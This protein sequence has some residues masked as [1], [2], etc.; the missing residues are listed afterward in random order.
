MLLFNNQA[1]TRI[2]LGK[3]QET[4]A[5]TTTPDRETMVNTLP[6]ILEDADNYISFE[7]LYRD[8]KKLFK[9]GMPHLSKKKQIEMKAKYPKTKECFK[10][11][12][13]AKQYIPRKIKK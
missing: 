8:F 7:E 9:A 5:N 3:M 10:N 2:N 4:L 11:L 12:I 13:F 1:F 6:G